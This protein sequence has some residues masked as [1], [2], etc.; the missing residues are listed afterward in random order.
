MKAF[1]NGKSRD[2]Q[3]LRRNDAPAPEKTDEELELPAWNP[4]ELHQTQA[5]IQDLDKHFTGLRET[6][7]RRQVRIDQVRRSLSILQTLLF[8]SRR[9]WWRR[10][11][12]W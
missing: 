5:L 6:L 9:S 1:S 10:W 4:E 8:P 12:P 7:Q 2:R 11:F 3:P